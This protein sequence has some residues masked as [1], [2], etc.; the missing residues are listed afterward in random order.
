MNCI[1]ALE[2]VP[3][4]ETCPPASSPPPGEH[5]ANRRT[6]VV[7]LQAAAR[8]GD[9]AERDRLRRKAADLI[10]SETPGQS[11]AAQVTRC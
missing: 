10:L 4:P 2:R 8:S 6:A 9:A 1:P 3:G 11:L 7:C 5:A